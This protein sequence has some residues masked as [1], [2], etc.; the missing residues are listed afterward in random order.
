MGDTGGRAGV[1]KKA[2]RTYR[3][4][5][6]QFEPVF[7]NKEAN[8]EKMESMTRT[9]ALDGA[10]LVIFPECCV[11]GYGTG[12]HVRD[13]ARLADVA[14]GPGRGRAVR[15][16]EALARELDV[17]LVFGLPERVD[18]I[19][20]NSAVCV[21]P[22]AGVVGSARK[23]HLWDADAEV[24]ASGQGFA[25]WDGPLGRVGSLVC[26][27][28]EFPEAARSLALMGAHLLAVSTANM[29]PW[30]E[31]QRVYVRARA[32]E[33]S[34][35]VALCNCVGRSE[36]T[37][38]FGGSVIV[39]PYGHILAEAGDAEAVLVADIDLELIDKAT[40]D[41]DYIHKRR[42]DLYGWT[43]SPS[44]GANAPH[45]TK[46]GEVMTGVVT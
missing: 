21:R 35:F 38:F 24:F 5:V 40:R 3:I 30:E 46:I 8:L 45:P 28:L 39:D 1:P 2:S 43:C 20:Y 19:T 27:D 12:D 25:V 32:M 10:R 7:L 13:M 26:Y 9:A 33:N 16:M 29:R 41:L 11:T 31:F 37:E 22:D 42:E 17:Y 6:C 23:L 4:A 15:R 14:I 36:A 18:E 34:L 44:A